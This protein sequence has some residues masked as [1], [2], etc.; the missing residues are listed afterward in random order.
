M[1]YK[2]FISPVQVSVAGQILKETPAIPRLLSVCPH[3]R[4]YVCTI[5]KSKGSRTHAAQ[6]PVA[7]PTI[8]TTQTIPTT[9]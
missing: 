9:T 8:T 6:I 7:V 5:A 1:W 4:C 2:M 3:Q